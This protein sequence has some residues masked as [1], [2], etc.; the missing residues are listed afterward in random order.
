MRPQKK[1]IVLCLLL[2]LAGITGCFNQGPPVPEPAP[3]EP[4]V[5]HT[6]DVAVYYLK[7]TANEMYLIREVHQTE[8]SAA[9]ARVA[10]EELI[11]GTP[12]TEGAY[13][14]LPENTRILDIDIDQGLATVNFSHEVL[15]A[16]VGASG[17]ELGIASIVNTLTEFPAIQRVQFKVDGEVEK[18]MDW[19]GHVGLYEQPFTRNLSLVYEP[20]IWVTAPAANQKISSPVKIMGTARVFEATV[21]FHLKDAKGNIIARGFTTATE[22]A[23]DRGDFEA[24]LPF[25]SLAGGKGQL[26]VFEVSMKD[27]SEVNKVVIPV[28]WE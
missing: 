1:H 26:E 6:M 12:S 14:V 7:A 9:V 21:S 13:R 5:V 10:L 8:N 24:E 16:N 22:G 23:P 4:P 18:A 15:E 25:N 27:G 2:F 17:E 11:T 28:E 20:V 3:T 19:W